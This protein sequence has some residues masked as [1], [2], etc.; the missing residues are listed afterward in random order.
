MA[1]SPHPNL[2]VLDTVEALD[3]RLLHVKEGRAERHLLIMGP[4]GKGK[5]LRLMRHFQPL[6]AADHPKCRRVQDRLPVPYYHG[7]ITPGKWYIRGWQ[8]QDDRLLILNDPH[9]RPTDADWESMLNQFLET[10]GEREIRWDLR[11]EIS[12]SAA[13]RSE[14]LRYFLEHGFPRSLRRQA[15]GADPDLAESLPELAAWDEADED[16]ESGRPRLLI[17]SHYLTTSQVVLVAN[18]LGR[19]WDRIMSRL[20]GFWYEPSVDS[21]LEDMARWDPPVPGIILTLLRD[22]HRRGE[23]INLDLRKV[24]EAIEDLRLGEDWE[25]PLARSFLPAADE[26]LMMDV[27]MILD[28]LVDDRKAQVGEEFTE[29][30]LYHALQQFRPDKGGGR[31]N[32]RRHRALEFLV[33][34]GIIERCRPARRPGVLHGKSP[35]RGFRVLRLP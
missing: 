11:S 26:E 14:I 24:D 35:G 9:I 10:A 7:R 2:R 31:G 21:M 5:T 6:T 23:I 8:H 34:E 32:A 20:R 15:G 27:G 19:G 12:L 1:A 29:S 3:R 25:S 4:P 13:D 22:W 17:P 18:Q 16:D 28:W 30:Q 33:A